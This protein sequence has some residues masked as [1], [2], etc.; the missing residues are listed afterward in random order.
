ML[1]VRVFIFCLD[2][3]AWVDDKDIGDKEVEYREISFNF[4]LSAW[5]SILTVLVLNEC[6]GFKDSTTGWWI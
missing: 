5:P 6:I 4:W 3:A 2:K 1:V